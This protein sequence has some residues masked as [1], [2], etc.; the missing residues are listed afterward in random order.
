MLFASRCMALLQHHSASVLASVSNSAVDVLM[1]SQTVQLTAEAQHLIHHM[2]RPNPAERC[3]TEDI[4][5]HPWFTKNLPPELAALNSRL[6]AAK[7]AEHRECRRSLADLDR[8]PTSVDDRFP[9]SSQSR[10]PPF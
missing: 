9:L 1:S 8:C 3:T 7:A 5:A 4:M 10:A 2:F 6:L